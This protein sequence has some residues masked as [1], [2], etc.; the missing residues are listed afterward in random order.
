MRMRMSSSSCALVFRRGGIGIL[1][2]WHKVRRSVTSCTHSDRQGAVGSAG[3]QASGSQ[4]GD[5]KTKEHNQW[6]RC[7]PASLWGCRVSGKCPAWAW[8]NGRQAAASACDAEP[9]R[10]SGCLAEKAEAG[11]IADPAQCWEKNCRAQESH[12]PGL[13]HLRPP[14]RPPT[15]ASPFIARNVSVSSA[16]WGKTLGLTVVIPKTQVT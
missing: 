5:L 15:S 13:P 4:G 9:A 14:P 7:L 11:V 10:S 12:L 3:K 8:R 6:L 16:W 1:P 2:A